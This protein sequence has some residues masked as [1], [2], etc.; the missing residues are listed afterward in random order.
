[1][2][3]LNIGISHEIYGWI[4]RELRLTGKSMAQIVREQPEKA[5]LRSGPK[6][7]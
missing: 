5:K 7:R 6:M 2:H 3:R 1:M 4:K